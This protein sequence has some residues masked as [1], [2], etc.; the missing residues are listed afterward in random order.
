MRNHTTRVFLLSTVVA[1]GLTFSGC[2]KSPAQK[3][4]EKLQEEVNSS[5]RKLSKALSLLSMPTFQDPN[6]GQRIDPTGKSLPQAITVAPPSYLDAEARKALQ[7]ASAALPKAIESYQAMEEAD[8]ALIG[9]ARSVLARVQWNLARFDASQAS[10]HRTEAR[11]HVARAQEIAQTIS[12]QLDQAAFL[13]SVISASDETLGRLRSG[14]GQKIQTLQGQIQTL[15]KELSDANQKYNELAGQHVKL[16][17]EATKLQL[18]SSTTSGREGLDL[19][20][21]AMKLVEQASELASQMAQYEKTVENRRN[22]LAQLRM[23]LAGDE[24]L[25]Q[26]A[27]AMATGRQQHVATVQS[28]RDRLWQSVQAAITPG[29]QPRAD[30]PGDLAGELAQLT[31]ALGQASGLADPAADL[32]GQGASQFSKASQ[33]Y[34]RSESG[35]SREMAEEMNVK[36]ADVLIDLGNLNLERVQLAGRLTDLQSKLG[37]LYSQRLNASLPTALTEAIESYVPDAQA[38]SATAAEQFSTALSLYDRI[39]PG[40][41]RGTFWAYQGRKAAALVG[42]YQ[43]SPQGQGQGQL[44]QAYQLLNEALADV[45]SQPHMADLVAYRQLV[46]QLRAQ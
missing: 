20:Q 19:H 24:Q 33:A 29:S 8:P 37:T 30:S 26:M 43:A 3:E 32:L 42:L 44:D 6:S 40:R 38:L 7:E 31:Q 13:D 4:G 35:T 1:L 5:L 22:R 23:Q 25:L 27:D 16:L 34:S 11:Y 14:Q 28:L 2:G 45:E 17:N 12:T 21:Q 15:Q 41:H 18:D 9:A 46:D 36:Q 10:L 39:Q